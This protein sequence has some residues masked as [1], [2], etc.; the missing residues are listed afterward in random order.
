VASGSTIPSKSSPPIRA[1]RNVTRMYPVYDEAG[2]GSLQAIV[3][4][5]GSLL[6]RDLQKDP[7]G[8]DTVAIAAPVVDKVSITATKETDGTLKQVSVTLRSTEPLD[9]TTAANGG[10]LA[11]VTATCT[12]VH[13]STAQ[14]ALSGDGFT[15]TWTL[16][17]A[18]WTALATQ[19]SASEVPAA[20]SVAATSTL[21]STTYGISTPVLPA[22]PEMLAKGNVYSTSALPLEI[23]E[24]L[25]LVSSS[26]TSAGSETPYDVLCLFAT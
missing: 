3:G 21:R 9:A 4:E 20:L 23:R 8:E 2:A 13:T 19:G 10:R 16:A 11:S 17:A 5:D 18:D 1:A 24:P 15:L 12:V 25:T 22:T 7:C 6:A 26:L 14:P